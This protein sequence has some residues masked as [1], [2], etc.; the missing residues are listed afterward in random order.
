VKQF[1]LAQFR[2][3]VPVSEP[4]ARPAPTPIRAVP[5]DDPYGF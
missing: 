4:A 5:G 1:F 2:G 3:V